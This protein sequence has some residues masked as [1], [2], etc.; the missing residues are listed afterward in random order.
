MRHGRGDGRAGWGVGAA[1]EHVGSSAGE[2]SWAILLPAKVR[3]E[4]A[5]PLFQL[6]GQL[7]DRNLAKARAVVCRS[8]GGGNTA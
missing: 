5:A 4:H 7:L 8:K 1:A 6:K 2:G 3:R